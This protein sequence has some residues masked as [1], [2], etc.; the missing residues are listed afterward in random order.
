MRQSLPRSSC[1]NTGA[2]RMKDDRLVWLWLANGLGPAAHQLPQLIEY[3]GSAAD[4]FS[5]RMELLREKQITPAQQKTLAASK[6]EDFAAR[7]AQHTTQGITVL[8]YDDTAYPQLLRDTDAPPAV[9][10]VK[11]DVACLSP[12]L[13]V[14]MVGTRRPSAYGVDAAAKLADG[15]A[16]AGVTLISGLA[17]GLDSEAHKAA[18]RANVPT[19]AVL[20]TAIDVCF[21]ARNAALRDCIEQCGAVVSEFPIGTKGQ[22]AYF[23]LRNR[24]IAGLSRALCVIEARSRS[25]TMSTVRCALD[26]GRDV[27]AVPGSIFSPLSEGT[28]ALLAEGARVLSCADD[29]LR[30]YT[31]LLPQPLCA[32]Q[33][34]QQTLQPLFALSPDGKIMQTVLTTTPKGLAL[35]CEETGLSSAAAMAALTELEL[36]GVSLQQPGRLFIKNC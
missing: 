25:G 19:V 3:Y 21:P 8:T 26:Y 12:R 24:I 22:S 9:L 27:F 17:D 33:P 15:L 35:L 1:G 31:A 32:E 36:A 16:A 23:L 34:Q 4:I 18:V 29:L 30:D 2:S 11:G 7:L 13:P 20:G 14:G 5:H 6:P 28:N 10:Y